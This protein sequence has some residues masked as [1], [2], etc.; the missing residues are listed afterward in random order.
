MINTRNTRVPTTNHTVCNL[1]GGSGAR[2][3]TVQNSYN[4]VE[5]TGCGFVYVNP[6][7]EPEVLRVLYA[8]YLKSKMEDA[9]TWKLYMDDVFTWTAELLEKRIPGKGS[10]LD[11]GCGYG[12]FVEKI[13]QRGWNGR[14]IDI[15]E[16]AVKTARKRGLDVRCMT[17]EE[18]AHQGEQFDA[19]TM[20]YVLEHLNDPAHALETIKS[21]VRP[22]GLLVLRVPHTT[23]IV[24]LLKIIRIKNNLY[25]PPFH[26]CDFSPSTIRAILKKT[27]YTGIKTFIG[28]KTLPDNYFPSAVSR[29]TG[30]LANAL[31]NLSGGAL[32]LP[33]VSKTTVAV[34]EA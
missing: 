8:D 1:C 33:G 5:C 17:I 22:G 23:P 32:L 12:F 14:G 4:I 20:F 24:K 25:D 11:I 9:G 26:L 6:R 2:R 34:R 16:P 7:P 21:L 19:V 29:S 30:V 15:S 18:I 3:I 27:G 10:V 28:G 13:C 31:F